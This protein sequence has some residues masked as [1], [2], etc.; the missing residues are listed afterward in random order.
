MKKVNYRSIFFVFV[1]ALSLSCYLFLHS[2]QNELKAEAV[3]E[4]E[5]I[6]VEESESASEVFMP[7]VELVKKVLEVSKAILHPFSK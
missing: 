6:E 7:D 3:V 2:V 4:T 5:F 1:A